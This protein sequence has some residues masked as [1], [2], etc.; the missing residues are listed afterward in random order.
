MLLPAIALWSDTFLHFTM[1]G[2][3]F[4]VLSTRS[5]HPSMVQLVTLVC[6]F[7][8]YSFYCTY[9]SMD[10]DLHT[11][12]LLSLAQP[13]LARYIGPH[14]LQFQTL[15][16]SCTFPPTASIAIVRGYFSLNY[17]ESS[18][19]VSILCFLILCMNQQLL[20]FKKVFRLGHC[21]Q[22]VGSLV[23]HVNTTWR[24][25]LTFNL[26][27]RPSSYRNSTCSS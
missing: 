10:P 23:H 7:A 6:I 11:Y 14:F 21:V 16:F 12:P 19:T 17:L 8:F 20:S 24:I 27:T 15:D 5:I 25:A 22:L 9:H 26:A 13:C 3:H 18:T 4:L 1:L 2:A